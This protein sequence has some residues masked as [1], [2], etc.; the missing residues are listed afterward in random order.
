MK[1]VSLNTWAGRVFDPLM[2]FVAEQGRDTDVFCFQEVFD[3][4]TSAEIVDEHYRTKLFYELRKRLPEHT[5]HFA[6]AAEGHG[7]FGP[8]DFPL[9]WG[10]AM[11]LRNG[12]NYNNV[13]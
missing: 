3:T 4:P 5:G 7:F 10:L 1:L 2:D 11:F 12:L 6:S 9:F 8:V 13:S